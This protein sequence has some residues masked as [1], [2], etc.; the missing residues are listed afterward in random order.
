MQLDVNTYGFTAA[1]PSAS[2]QCIGGWTTPMTREQPQ[3]SWKLKFMPL[4]HQQQHDRVKP[5]SQLTSRQRGIWGVF[6]WNFTFLK[7]KKKKKVEID[8]RGIAQEQQLPS[9]SSPGIAL[10]NLN[11]ALKECRWNLWPL[12]RECSALRRIG[13]FKDLENITVWTWVHKCFH[14]EC[15]AKMQRAI[16]AP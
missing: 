3:A 15:Y 16:C 4:F 2:F 5:G 11:A 8:P 6:Q 14:T 7:K 12:T 9:L 10:P 1:R 13:W